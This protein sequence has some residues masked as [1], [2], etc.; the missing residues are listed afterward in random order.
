MTD[1]RSAPSNDVAPNREGERE[2][3]NWERSKKFPFP[4]STYQCPNCKTTLETGLVAGATTPY[5]CPL[6]RRRM[7][8]MWTYYYA[9]PAQ[10]SRFTYPSR[11]YF[12]KE[13]V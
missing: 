6:D 10:G 11:H 5:L 3:S 12:G 13:I 8:L 9:T 4:R 1:E 7:K 2:C